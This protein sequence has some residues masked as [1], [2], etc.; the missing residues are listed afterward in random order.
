VEAAR[1][2]LAG[3]PVGASL[4]DMAATAARAVLAEVYR[5]PGLFSSGAT[6]ADDA[7]RN[8][9]TRSQIAALR[10]VHVGTVMTWMQRYDDFPGPVRTDTDVPR[11]WWPDV[12]AYCESNRLPRHRQVP[13]ESA[14][15]A[16]DARILEMLALFPQ[17]LT[18]AEIAALSGEEGAEG[19]PTPKAVQVR[20]EDRLRRMEASRRVRRAPKKGHRRGPSKWILLDPAS[21]GDRTELRAAAARSRPSGSVEHG[22]VAGLAYRMHGDEALPKAPP[23]TER[24][25]TVYARDRRGQNL[26]QL[27]VAEDGSASGLQV[28][29]PA[30]AIAGLARVPGLLTGLSAAGTTLDG[31]GAALAA[32]GA[33]DETRRPGPFAVTLPEIAGRCDVP[34]DT[35]R[36]WCALPGFP[37][38][39]QLAEDGTAQWWWPDVRDFIASSAA[40]LA[41]DIPLLAEALPPPP[42]GKRGPIPR[43]WIRTEF[44]MRL[45]SYMAVQSDEIGRPRYTRAQIAASLLHPV[46][47]PVVSQYLPSRGRG[48]D[49]RELPPAAIARI[50]ALRAEKGPDGEH[51]YT[52]QQLADMVGVHPVSIARHC[53]DLAFPGKVGN[54]PRTATPAAGGEFM[55]P[56]LAEQAE[57]L[58]ARRDGDGNRLHTLDQLGVSVS[59][60][61]KA[62]RSRRGV[63]SP[64]Q[65]T[66]EQ[67][68]SHGK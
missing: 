30:A 61:R 39:M 25:I 42:R 41:G 26:W 56:S 66:A 32:L 28:H 68:H 7:A 8:L 27:R 16:R 21:A 37:A 10:G 35:A 65:Y 45:I 59:D 13:A 4:D 2:A 22:P 9:V 58:Y 15:A 17:G 1:Q 38:P 24:Q 5:H 36:S 47:A 3:I 6:P 20:Y 43:N 29:A 34:V 67:R 49:P 31:V 48:G 52:L 55:T 18:I 23:G 63:R 40:A 44:D 51:V 62:L 12:L 46:P 11:W 60:T 64:G 33:S 19:N 57:V 53:V 54:V 14:S 50:R